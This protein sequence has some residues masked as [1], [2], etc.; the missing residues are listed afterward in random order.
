MATCAFNDCCSLCSV[1]IPSQ[2]E[3]LTSNVFRNCWS[4]ARLT[5]EL[6]SHLRQFEFPETHDLLLCIPDSVET[7][8]GLIPCGDCCH[9]LIQFGPESRLVQMKLKR[10]TFRFFRHPIPEWEY[11]LFV[12]LPETVL[13]R[14]RLKLEDLW[15]WSDYPY[16][17]RRIPSIQ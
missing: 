12:S 9:R 5:F 7:L 4:L 13:R 14:F 3:I 1:E 6:P 10:P 17:H 2:V 11:G 16:R 15:S 8:S